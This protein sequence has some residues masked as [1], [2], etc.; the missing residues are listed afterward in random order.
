MLGLFSNCRVLHAVI[1]AGSWFERHRSTRE[2]DSSRL[3]VTDR[4]PLEEEQFD[5]MILALSKAWAPVP[6]S[7]TRDIDRAHAT[8]AYSTFAV[9]TVGR[10][11]GNLLLTG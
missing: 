9:S 7:P 4:W 6:L 8:N 5:A 1:D 10:T 2:G 3:A 11:F